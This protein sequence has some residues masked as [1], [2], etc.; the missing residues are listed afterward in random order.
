VI[1]VVDDTGGGQDLAYADGLH[2][3]GLPELHVWAR[4]AHGDDPGADFG[5][6]VDDQC[7]LLN[8]FG[9]QLRSGDL[10]PC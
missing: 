7:R 1:G 2:D 6:S 4:L 8:R 5:L 9:A 10:A 3:L